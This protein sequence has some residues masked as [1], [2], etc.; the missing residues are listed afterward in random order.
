[1]RAGGRVH[2]STLGGG[3]V[4][5]KLLTQKLG[6]NGLQGKAETFGSESKAGIAL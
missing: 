5:L 4:I 3:F 1:M 2:C 6:A